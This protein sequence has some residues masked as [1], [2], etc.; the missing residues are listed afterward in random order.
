MTMKTQ[1]N[2][3]PRALQLGLEFRVCPNVH[4][5]ATAAGNG[6]GHLT[7][8]QLDLPACWVL[9]PLMATLFAFRIHHWKIEGKSQKTGYNK[10]FGIV[11]AGFYFSLSFLFLVISFLQRM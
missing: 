2:E 10:K 5:S 1:L 9:S 3:P 6:G 8:R 4:P 7:Q 11:A